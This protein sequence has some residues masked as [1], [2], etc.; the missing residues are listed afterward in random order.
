MRTVSAVFGPSC[1]YEVSGRKRR[2][3]ETSCNGRIQ[4][5]T[6]SR[7]STADSAMSA[8]SP[9]PHVPD[10]SKAFSGSQAASK[11][12][13]RIGFIVARCGSTS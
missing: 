3:A 4:P 11:K 8:A 13:T 6:Y 7:A 2:V 9:L 1:R 12:T 10:T 5:V